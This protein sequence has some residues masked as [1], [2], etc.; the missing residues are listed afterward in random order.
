V[1]IVR[2]TQTSDLESL[3]RFRHDIYVE[4]LGWLPPSRD[5]LVRDDFDD[6]AYNYAAFDDEGSVVGSV[7]VVPDSERGLPLERYAPLNGYRAGKILV[8]TCR[9]AVHPDSHNTRLGVLLM[10]AGFQRSAMLGATHGVVDVAVE[11]DS[12]RL[13]EKIGFVR[14]GDEYVDNHHLGNL[15]SVTMGHAVADVYRVWPSEKPA[16]YRLF[17]SVD[18]CIDHG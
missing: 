10:T 16:L 6:L 13:Y 8:E 5:G 2:V 1:R 18:V 4:Q 9:L 12:L 7:R 3:Y 14:V 15:R 11:T 17:T